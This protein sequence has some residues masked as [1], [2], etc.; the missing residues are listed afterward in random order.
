MNIVLSF[1]SLG[2]NSLLWGEGGRGLP[3]FTTTPCPEPRPPKSLTWSSRRRSR[4]L[5]PPAPLEPPPWHTFGCTLR[6]E[7]QVEIRTYFRNLSVKL[8]FSFAQWNR[9]RIMTPSATPPFPLAL[10]F[11]PCSLYAILSATRK[12]KAEWRSSQALSLA[13]HYL[14]SHLHYRLN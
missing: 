8:S 7:T 3:P 6:K 9:H 12:M 1:C 14:L 13:Q 10:Y 4:P 11:S 2:N 5:P